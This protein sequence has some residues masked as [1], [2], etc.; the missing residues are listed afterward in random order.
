MTA[1]AGNMFSNNAYAGGIAGV[2]TGS[3]NRVYNSGVIQEN[4]TAFIPEKAYAGGI[5]AELGETAVVE[6]SVQL[7]KQITAS[8]EGET[9]CYCIASGNGS[10]VKNAAIEGVA[11]SVTKDA[12]LVK[13]EE[14]LSV[15]E[16]YEK[17]LGWDFLETWELAEEQ[18]LP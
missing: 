18:K 12:D 11:A 17:V 3:I 9:K 10:K 8:S 13:S 5:C 1:T 2:F 16:A 15:S 14:E 7:Q 4:V 6:N